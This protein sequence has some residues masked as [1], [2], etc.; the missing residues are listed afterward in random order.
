MA[1]LKVE[2]R[3]GQVVPFDPSKIESAVQKAAIAA[4]KSQSYIEKEINGLVGHVSEE[5]KERFED[6]DFIPNVENIHDIVE[7]HLMKEG[8]YE[9]AKTYILFRA[10][11]RRKEVEDRK[12]M[13]F[14]RKL[15]VK[16]SDGRTVLFNPKKLK[17]T[18]ERCCDYFSTSEVDDMKEMLFEETTKN[19]YDGISSDEIDKALLMAAS[20]LIEINPEYDDVASR[21]FQQKI[22]KEVFGFSTEFGTDQAE[23]AYRNSFIHAIKIGCKE[24]IYDERLQNFNLERLSS[25]LVIERD[26]LIKYMGLQ[27]L[28]ERYFVRIKDRLVE[29]PQT[30]LMRVAMGLSINE[31]DKEGRAEE[32][33]DVMSN[34]LYIPST[35]TLFN[36]GTTH[37]QLSSCFD[38][39]TNVGRQTAPSG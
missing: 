9:V 29:L 36:S 30:F 27:T 14:L 1:S 21:F 32:F 33:Y 20:S 31:D 5:I 17:D 34:L 35:P 37:P 6:N 12:K 13:S 38:P 3:D 7:K 8:H 18:I 16:K 28:C 26:D 25:K 10:D 11:R 24:K 39:D 22:R 15:T 19:I 23:A 4:G 2:K